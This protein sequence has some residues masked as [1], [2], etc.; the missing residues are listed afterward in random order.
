MSAAVKEPFVQVSDSIFPV[1][2]E[3]ENDVFLVA[4]IPK[5]LRLLRGNPSY[6]GLA[7]TSLL[8]EAVEHLLRAQGR[9]IDPDLV[10]TLIEDYKHQIGEG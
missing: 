9:P 6:S 5:M 7:P 1:D 8:F 4:A 10:A 2:R 3:A